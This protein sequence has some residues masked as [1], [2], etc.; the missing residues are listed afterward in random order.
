MWSDWR[1][2]TDASERDHC[3]YL[4][5][6]SNLGDRRSNLAAALR[7]LDECAR[8][9]RISSVWE[10][11]PVGP[12]DQP[13]YWNLVV[14][15]RTGLDAGPLLMELKRIERRLGRTF[16]VRWGPRVID[17]DI[18]LYDRLVSQEPD[19]VVPHPRMLERAFVLR[20]LA[21][22]EPNLTHP[23]TGERIADRL[24]SGTF[25]QTRRLFPGAE[26]LASSGE[27]AG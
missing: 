7:L 24:A 3:V 5:L 2:V 11:E 26:L 21:E 20:P 18:L 13:E 25:E 8:V 9:E 16:S 4:G 1:T 10:S 22:V 19:L 14:R 12:P 15:V 27:S 17:L 6:G 23:E